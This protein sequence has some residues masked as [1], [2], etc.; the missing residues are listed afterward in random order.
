MPLS[1]KSL[2]LVLPSLRPAS[3]DMVVS[4]SKA[5]FSTPGIN[6]N[7]FC[8]TPAVPIIPAIGTL[9]YARSD[10]P[11]PIT[12]CC[13]TGKHVASEMLFTGQ[14]ISAHRAHEM[15][16]VNRIVDSAEELEEEVRVNWGKNSM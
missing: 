7:L 2:N 10:Q 11:L 5:F 4:H 1:L 16:L 15:G 3:C 12:R 8:S 9:V 13:C 14:S 6:I